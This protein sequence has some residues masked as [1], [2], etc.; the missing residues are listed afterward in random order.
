MDGPDAP[1]K[2][3]PAAIFLTKSRREEVFFDCFM[4]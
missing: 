2:A 3:A 4:P 1:N